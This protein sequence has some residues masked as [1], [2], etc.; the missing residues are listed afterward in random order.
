MSPDERPPRP[1]PTGRPRRRRRGGPDWIRTWFVAVLVVWVL[2]PFAAASGAAQDALPYVAAGRLVSD[3]PEAVY[4]TTGDRH[5]GIDDAFAQ[6]YCSLLDSQ[7]VRCDQVAVAFL[8]TPLALPFAVAISPLSG[9]AASLLMRSAA[10]VLL[11]AGMALVWKRLAHRT[12]RAPLQ[13]LL[14]AV[15]LTPLATATI[16]FA[17]TSPVMFVSVL[18]GLGATSRAG[19]V[20]QVLAWV[21]ASIFKAFPAALVLVLVWLRRWRF[22]AAAAAVVAAAAAV[23]ALV[24]PASIVSDFLDSTRAISAEGAD[25]SITWL[26]SDLTGVDGLGRAAAVLVGAACCWFGLV[27]TEPDV[28]WAAGYLAL[29]VV[30]PLFQVHYLWVPLGAVVVA[31]AAQRRLGKRSLTALPV[32]ALLTIPPSLADDPTR[33]FHPTHQALLV[34]VTAAA[35]CW[36]AARSRPATTPTANTPAPD[37]TRRP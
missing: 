10:A 2:I 22:L 35:F 17:Q 3:R 11:A 25:G 18:G 23:T 14:T 32:L 36:F 7:V 30:S 27:R 12:R 31:L 5:T 20:A 6:E 29:V 34:V 15:A 19:R 24:A 1:G 33:G 13:L 8:A 37:R 21:A 26:V 4:P 28:R 16:G 9:V